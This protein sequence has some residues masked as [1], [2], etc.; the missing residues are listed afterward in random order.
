M[1]EPKIAV[2][3]AGYWGKNL[4]R[5]FHELGALEMLVDV[6]ADA[7]REMQTRFRGLKIESSF[8]RVLTNP[9]IQGVV[10][11]TP[12][13][14]HY[15][16][17]K[18][19][20]QAGK[21]VFVE[22]PLALHLN[23]GREL[24]DLARAQKKIL[25]VGHILEYHPAFL[26]IREVIDAGAIGRL[27]YIYSSRLNFGKIRREENILWSFAPHDVALIL[28]LVKEM[29]LQVVSMGGCYIQPNIADVTVTQLL[30]NQGVMGHIFVSWLNPFKE[31]RFV[32]VG[33]KKMI[34]F[35][36]INKNLILHDL[37]VDVE[38]GEPTPIKGKGDP[39]EYSQDEPLKLECQAFLEAIRTGKPPLT[40]GESGYRVL[41]VLHASQNS[42]SLQGKPVLVDSL[43]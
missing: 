15:T 17:A 30:F 16:M 7:T 42:L 22:K 23:E 39:L 32:I 41:Q 9:A 38:H 31:Q 18:Q 43:K 25:M 10:I 29:P 33:S 28:R 40:D 6:N 12:A 27:Q 1:M 13:V 3:G 2:A 14:M 11:A 34:Q 35:D 20:L 5:S 19:A 37:H 8:E 21:H 36:D 4:V 26:K 24:V